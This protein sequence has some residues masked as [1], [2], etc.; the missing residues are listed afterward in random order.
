MSQYQLCELTCM[1]AVL[2]PQSV[3]KLQEYL[4]FVWDPELPGG[5]NQ[6]MKVL[7]DGPMDQETYRVSILVLD[8]IHRI[9]IVLCLLQAS[10]C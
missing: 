4:F 7:E 10:F 9:K 2:R 3:K 1:F 5:E 6:P 8:L